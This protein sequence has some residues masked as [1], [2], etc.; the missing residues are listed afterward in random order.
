MEIRERQCGTT[1]CGKLALFF[2]HRG[3]LVLLIHTAVRH[4]VTKNSPSYPSSPVVIAGA[5]MVIFGIGLIG[6]VA[7]LYYRIFPLYTRRLLRGRILP[8]CATAF[9]GAANQLF[10]Y[11]F[12]LFPSCVFAHHNI[13]EKILVHHCTKAIQIVVGCRY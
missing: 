6:E 4:R 5:I 3:K 12:L 2:A 11:I 13:A 8:R 7:S 1:L 10:P 9:I